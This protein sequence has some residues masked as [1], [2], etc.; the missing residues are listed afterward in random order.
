MYLVWWV[1]FFV[2]LLLSAGIM[3]TYLSRSDR[4]NQSS[5]S[6]GVQRFSTRTL[7][8]VPV[9]GVDYELEKNL[10]SLKGQKYGQFELI[11]VV[12][13]ETDPAVEFLKNA[14]V[15]YTESIEIC[16]ECSGKVRAIHSAL[17]KYPDFDRYVV[18]DSDIRVEDSWLQNLLNP[19]S[20]PIVGVA[21]TFPVF[22]PE[23]GF[24][25]KLK[26][27]WGLVGQSM[28]ESRLTRFVWG[29]SMAFRKDLIDEDALK[30]LSHAISDDIA[31][32]RIA[33]KKGLKVAYVPEAR[34]RIYSKD[35]FPTF[36]EWSNRQTAFSIYSTNKT[37][38]FGM[39]YYLVFIYLLISSILLSVFVNLLFAVFLFPYLYNS[40]S[41]LKKV[42]VK[43]WYFLALTFI[44]PFVY[45]WNLMSGM[46]R[47]RVVWRGNRYSLS[48]K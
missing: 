41:S 24:W 44:L 35:D 29:G 46:T 38:A 23:G 28:M 33:K 5:R 47:K 20:D 27:F 14:G 26:T 3:L 25:S 22:F 15:K 19:L 17:V 21:T 34:P 48:K 30:L 11:A 36:M 8:I 32:L 40:V 18:A 12:D 13:D 9:K 10:V 16:T 31:I 42:P 1:V 4:D 45:V 39:I 43:V 6:K 7:V 2:N 37:F